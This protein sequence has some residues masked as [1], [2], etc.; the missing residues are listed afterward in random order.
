MWHW[1]HHQPDYLWSTTLTQYRKVFF[2][3]CQYVA[4]QSIRDE[5]LYNRSAHRGIDPKWQSHS[6]R[7]WIPAVHRL[8]HSPSGILWNINDPKLNLIWSSLLSVLSLLRSIYPLIILITGINIREPWISCVKN[9][10]RLLNKLRLSLCRIQHLN[11][12]LANN[13][14]C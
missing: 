7:K 11:R 3:T 10:Q 8:S 6:Q 14:V 12:K 9:V 5:P 2:I 1:L 4:N 13:M